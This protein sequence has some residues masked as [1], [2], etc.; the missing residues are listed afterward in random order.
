MLDRIEAAV[1]AEVERLEAMNA[2]LHRAIANEQYD[3]YAVRTH[4]VK[5]G[6]KN[7]LKMMNVSSEGL[8][9][10]ISDL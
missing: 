6:S 4:T 3:Q 9:G 5:R 7:Y 1:N 2:S 10:R 8:K